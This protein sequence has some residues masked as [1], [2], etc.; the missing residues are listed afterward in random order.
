MTFWFAVFRA[1]DPQPRGS[2]PNEDV[3]IWVKIREKYMY[4]KMFIEDN[5]YGGDGGDERDIQIRKA[6]VST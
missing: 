3:E 1:Q 4:K 5:V 6:L 2:H